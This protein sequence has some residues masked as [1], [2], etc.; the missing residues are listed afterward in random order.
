MIGELEGSFVQRALSSWLENPRLLLLGN[1]ELPRVPIVSF[2]IRYP[3]AAR[4]LG[5]LHPNFVVALLD[6]L[7]GIQA[8][9]GCFC[10]GPYIHRLVD[11]DLET[12]AAHKAE[13]L[14]G[15]L[16]IKLGFVRLSFKYFMS[17]RVFQYLVEAIDF[18]ADHA[19]KLLPLYSFDPES[20]L[21]HHRDLPRS[22]PATLEDLERPAHGRPETAPESVLPGYIETAR[23]IVEQV[24]A[25]P[26]EE[27]PP[28][29]L[30]A[31]FE[32]LRWF[33]LPADALAAL[34]R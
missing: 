33:P 8:R 18:L 24:E 4:P 22:A 34:T 31:E 16:G 1:P 7:F 19:W 6:D 15:R 13:V 10:A 27:V 30:S 25:S 17:E 32:R 3:R 11:F 2:G 12:S 28:L 21:W 5:M 29:H 23:R 26:P 20:A 9:S 14:R